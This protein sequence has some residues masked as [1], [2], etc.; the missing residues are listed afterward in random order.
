MVPLNTVLKTGDMIEIKTSKSQLGPSEGWLDFVASSS[1]KSAIKKY[2]AKKN[3]SLLR[4]ERIAKGKQSCVDAFK[5]RGIDEEEMMKMLGAGKVLDY[6][7]FD[8]VDD[9]FIGVS[10][11]KP[12]ANALIEYLKIKRPVDLSIN[13]AKRRNSKI[14]S[15]PVYCKGAGKIAIALANCCTP[16]PGD[17]IIGYITKG[18]GISVH[19]KNCPN[20]AHAKERLIDVFWREDIEFATYPVDIVIEASDRNNLLVDVMAV[21]NNTKVGV[22]NLSARKTYPLPLA[23][24]S[25]CQTRNAYMISVYNFEVLQVSIVST[26]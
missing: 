8:A 5:E 19:R 21:F 11:R 24:Q 3:A 20:V 9:L 15:C 26:V 1:A 22:N 18:K 2:I 25:W 14:D 23:Q 6:Y 12:T 4:E 17:D 16:I 7:G 13:L 10:G